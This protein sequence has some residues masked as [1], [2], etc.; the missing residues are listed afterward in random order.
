M[1][2]QVH[3]FEVE[4]T[5]EGCSGA[6]QRVLEK[7]EGQGVNK[8]EIDLPDKRVFVDSTL[9]SEKPARGAQGRRAKLVPNVGVKA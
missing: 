6:V 8:V 2:S 4:M 7:L 9:G 3:E 5:C 1:A